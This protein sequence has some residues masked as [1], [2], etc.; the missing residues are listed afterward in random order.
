M[1]GPQPRS[2]VLKIPPY[3]YAQH[4]KKPSLWSKINLGSNE[5]CLGASPMVCEVLKGL[6][7]DWHRY[8]DGA[9]HDLKETLATRYKID[10]K[11][12]ICGNGSD[13]IIGFIARAY[14]EKGDEILFPAYSFI[15]Y[16]MAA[17]AVG[18]IPVSAPINQDFSFDHQSILDEVT[19]HTKIVFMANPNNPTGF[20]L[21]KE[22]IIKLRESLPENILLVLDAAYDDYVDWPEYDP[23]DQLVN[24][25]HNVIVTRTFSK[26]HGLA[27]LR[28]GWA[29]CPAEIAETLD[30]LRL[31]FNVNSLGQLAAMTALSDTDHIEKS[32]QHNNVEKAK[33]QKALAD[34][35]FKVWPSWGNFLMVHH[36]NAAAIHQHLL[37]FNIITRPLG[38]Y[39]LP[40]YLRI[41][42]GTASENQ[43]LIER[44]H[45]KK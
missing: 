20:C 1:V 34:L 38:G 12:I 17:H 21:A 28:V 30:R 42:I 6:S 41:T 2:S 7:L 5:N 4:N 35:G 39:G 23:G 33:L 16:Q 22:E 9:I 11:Q 8:P 19:P 43:M 44:L 14:A 26:I 37:E 45:E 18:A 29:L 36:P 25:Y 24:T 15:A 13:E 31:P 32:R 10:P 27:A 40:D 3:P